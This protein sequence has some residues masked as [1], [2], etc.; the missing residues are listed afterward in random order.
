MREVLLL[1]LGL[2]SDDLLGDPGLDRDCEE[3]RLE[4][5]IAVEYEGG[6][7]NRG[8]TRDRQDTKRASKD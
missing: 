1:A 4:T 6:G 7:C 8:V 3:E 2:F 5:G